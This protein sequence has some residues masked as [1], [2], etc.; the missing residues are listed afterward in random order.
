M[1]WLLVIWLLNGDQHHVEEYATLDQCEDAG[2]LLESETECLPLTA[3]AWDYY[4][5]DGME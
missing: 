1:E 2:E 3:E 5:S 4:F